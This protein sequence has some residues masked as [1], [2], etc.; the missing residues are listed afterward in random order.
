MLETA[1]LAE[2]YSKHPISQ[3][4]KKACGKEL[5]PAR[6][7]NVEELG[8][9]GITAQVDGRAVAVGNA[10]LMA[11]LGLTAPHGR[12]GRHPGLCGH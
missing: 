5:D 7:A 11:K 6:A 3:S 4:L 1:A 9:Y 12:P 10:R 8:G 2:S